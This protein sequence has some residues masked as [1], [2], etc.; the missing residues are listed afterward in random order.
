MDDA[1]RQSI[2]ISEPNAQLREEIINF[3]LSAGY[4]EVAATDSLP[5]AL[6]EI[7]QSEYDVTV[8][9]AG[10]PLT[11]GLQFAADLASLKPSARIIF[12]IDA[13][14][15]RLWDQIAAQ[16]DNV[17][18]LIKADFARNLLYLLEENAQP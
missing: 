9:D 16:S 2:L 4:E 7:C 5:A 18:F 14:D 1:G 12:M 11:A 10:K 3:L 6:D 8:A 15:Q 17:R 13:E